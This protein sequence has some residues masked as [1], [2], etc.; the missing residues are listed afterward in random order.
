MLIQRYDSVKDALRYSI[1]SLKR[2]E[3]QGVVL[4]KHTRNIDCP[5]MEKLKDLWFTDDPVPLTY[6]WNWTPEIL[7]EML[8]RKIAC[9]K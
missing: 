7:D 6:R 2:C 8:D 3:C 9:G 4:R 1:P 5:F